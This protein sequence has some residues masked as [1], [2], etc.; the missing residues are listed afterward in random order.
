MPCPRR[1]YDAE[2]GFLF[3]YCWAATIYRL[4]TPDG[5]HHAA[6]AARADYRLLSALKMQEAQAE[7][8]YASADAKTSRAATPI[9]QRAAA[10]TSPGKN[11]PSL[12]YLLSRKKYRG[13]KSA[14]PCRRAV[15][16]QRGQG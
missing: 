8:R 13:L 9:G 16:M 14:A 15:S 7:R 5:R 10:P 11:L 6:T 2:V 1:R 12:A 3:D 4:V